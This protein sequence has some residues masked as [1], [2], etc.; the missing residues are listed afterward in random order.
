MK[1]RK[2]FGWRVRWI[3]IYFSILKGKD[4]TSVGVRKFS[5]ALKR[6]ICKRQDYLKLVRGLCVQ[7]EM[8]SRENES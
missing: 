7:F 1:T 6:N 4:K 8:N 5:L 2:T 3:Y